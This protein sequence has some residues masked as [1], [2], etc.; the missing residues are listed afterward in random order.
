MTIKWIPTIKDRSKPMYLTIAS[1]LADDIANG[2][3]NPDDLLPTQRDLADQLGIAIGTVTKAYAEAKK[4]GLI[5]ANGR[6]GTFVG[7]GAVEGSSLNSLIKPAPQIIDFSMVHP[8]YNCDPDLGKTLKDLA[9]R[10]DVSSLLR[11][12]HPEGNERHRQAGAEW[13]KRLGKD[14]AHES[15]ILTTGG[16]NGL[17]LILAA[18]TEP[19]DKIL[20]EELVYPG[21]KSVAETLNLSLSGVMMDAEGILPDALESACRQTNARILFCTPDIQNPTTGILSEERRRA[22]A[23]IAQKHD[24]YIIE[25]AIHRP[26]LPNPPRLL[27]EFVPERTFL[28]ASTSK[29]VASGLRVGFIIAP[30]N[31]HSKIFSKS[32]AINLMISPLPFEVFT[33]WIDDGTVDRTI[34]SKRKEAQIRQTILKKVLADF[35]IKTT[36]YAY[37]S[38]LMLPKTINRTQFSIKAFK[39]GVSVATSEVFAVDEAHAPEAAR[40]CIAAPYSNEAVKVG[41]KIIYDILTNDNSKPYSVY[42]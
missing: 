39:K 36:D 5:H 27:A 41:L 7:S 23:N 15:V 20:V 40:I 21:I 16:Q 14:V 10:A 25:D 6:R 30:E 34:E 31:L 17:F 11:Y 38:W 1:V 22:I 18:T 3:L 9:N 4:R 24:L 13:I 37:F 29:T 32:Q 2:R 42:L 26:L 12:P 8:I 35:E 28:L 33:T 19:G